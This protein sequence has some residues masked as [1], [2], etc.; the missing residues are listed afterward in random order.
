MLNGPLIRCVL[1]AESERSQTCRRLH[2]IDVG[3]LCILVNP[4]LEVSW[5]PMALDAGI[6]E[7][8]KANSAILV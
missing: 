8:S 2:A 7:P 4:A 6:E 1:K 5:S 3:T